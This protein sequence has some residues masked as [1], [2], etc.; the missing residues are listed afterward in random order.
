MKS[1]KPGGVPGENPDLLAE[2]PLDAAD[3]GKKAKKTGKPA[4]LDLFPDA[5]ELPLREGPKE[6][7]AARLERQRDELPVA[8]AR[9]TALEPGEVADDPGEPLPDD[10]S[11]AVAMEVAFARRLAAGL[12]D[13]LI[14]VLVGLVELAS[15][16]VFL[17]LRFPPAAL[18]WVAAFLALVA[19][20]LLVVTP[21][22]WGTTPGLALAD[23]K[24]RAEDGGSPTL[25]SCLLRLVG[26]GLGVLLVPLLVAAF[27]KRG[28]TLSDILSRTT[29]GPA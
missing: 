22:V 19:L 10:G 5:A 29:I 14:L 13:L 27:D 12:A 16:A 15:G 24:I 20:V 7:R 26:F 18:V 4:T 28:R 2:H 9:L 23:L 21:F 3:S 17:A 8:P 6:T 11:A 1:E 25:A